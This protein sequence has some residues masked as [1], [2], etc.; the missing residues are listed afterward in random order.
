MLQRRQLL[1]GLGQAGLAAFAGLGAGAA[2]ATARPQDFDTA[3]PRQPLL[4]PLKGVDDI[5]G[6]R[7]AVATLRGR[8]PAELRGRFYRNG[9]AL[10]ER[11]GQRYHHWFDGD[12]MVQQFSIGDGAVRHRG[13]LV[14]TRRPRCV[15]WPSPMRNCCTMPSPSN[16]WW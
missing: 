6:D 2:H 5:T 10:F 4:A 16:Q 11:G 7:D 13:R 3:T 12:G 1:L 9:P 14:R 8:W 15:T